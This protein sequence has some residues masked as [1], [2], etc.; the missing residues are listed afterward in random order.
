MRDWR[1]GDGGK[2]EEDCGK[3]EE[4]REGRG[5]KGVEERWEEEIYRE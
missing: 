1:R 3:G 5:S 4:R 2:R